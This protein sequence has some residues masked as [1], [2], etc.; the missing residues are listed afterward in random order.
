MEARKPRSDNRS[1]S[2]PA[3]VSEP[4]PPTAPDDD[5]IAE[6]EF[7]LSLEELGQTYAA[8]LGHGTLPYKPAQESSGSE[9]AAPPTFDPVAEELVEDDQ[10]PITP[11]SILEAILFVGRPDSQPIDADLVAGMMRGVRAAE[12]EHMVNELN[13]IYSTQ[14]HVLRIVASGSGFRMQL[15]EEFAGIGH[16]FH[17]SVREIKLSQAAIDCLAII[18]YRPGITREE[19]EEQRGQPSGSIL[20]QMVRRQLVEIRREGGKKDRARRYYPTARLL[21]LAGVESLDEL[22]LAEDFER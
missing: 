8:M 1:S 17:G 6:P 20:N 12:I 9:E 16:R 10:C 5:S 21:T 19:L 11:L 3:S 15:A 14:G 2:V 13:E 4:L 22:P 18:A 7:G